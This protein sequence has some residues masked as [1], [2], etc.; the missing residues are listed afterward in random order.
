MTKGYAESQHKFYKE[1]WMFFRWMYETALQE[2]YVMR[3]PYPY[4]LEKE[5]VNCG[6][7]MNYWFNLMIKTP[8]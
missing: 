6:Q 4:D 2:H 5:Y 7:A 3:T 1:Q 8:E